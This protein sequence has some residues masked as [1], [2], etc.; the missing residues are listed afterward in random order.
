MRL[1]QVDRRLLGALRFVDATTQMPVTSPLTVGSDSA[2]VL[3]NGTGLFIIRS[4]VG[5]E[6]HSDAFQQPPASPPIGSVAV[7]VTVADHSGQFLQRQCN[8]ALPRDPDP[9]HAAQ[10]NSL[11]VPT[12]FRLFPAPAAPTLAAWATVRA[13]VTRKTT[14]TPLS[15]VL[16]RVTRTSDSQLLASG[17]SDSR[18]E[19]LV[20]MAGIPVITFDSG[21]GPVI[22]KA[23]EVSIQAIFDPNGGAFPDPD[24][25]E[26]NKGSLPST[27]VSGSLS[28]GGVLVVDLSIAVP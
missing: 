28:S 27:T 21:A 6:G 19:A 4:A 20:A 18:G 23:T 16:I 2:S 13:H 24:A 1:E 7:T 9:S 11:F 26:K 5:L 15:G 25:L 3:R 14:S 10:A 8:V 17:L 12:E 22:A